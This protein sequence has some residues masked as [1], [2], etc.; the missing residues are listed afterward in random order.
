[1]NPA[2]LRAVCDSLNDE[3]GTGGQSKLAR[4]LD[5]HHSTV[6]RKLNGLSPITQSDELAIR[7]AVVSLPPEV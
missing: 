2:E 1:M 7:Q 4:L 6:W 5:W 3:R